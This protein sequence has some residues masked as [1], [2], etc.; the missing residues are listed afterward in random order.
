VS[1]FPEPNAQGDLTPEMLTAA[2]INVHAPA[3]DAAAS[4]CVSASDGQISAA[5]VAQAEAGG[6]GGG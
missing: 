3:V 2:G 1:N 5:N 4:A 6:G